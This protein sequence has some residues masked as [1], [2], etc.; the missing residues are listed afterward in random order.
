MHAD[1]C[2]IG[3]G[4]GG[5][6]A[7]AE[8]AEGGL[9]VVVLEEGPVRG[10][11]DATGRPR[12]TLPRLYRAGGQVATIGRPPLMLPLGRGTGGTTFVNSGTCFRTP[13]AVLDRWRAEHGIDGLTDAL[14]ERV[15]AALGVSE[16]TPE[17]AGRNAATIRRGAERLGWHGGYLRR[18][19]RGCR[20]S[21]VC[22]FGCPTGAKQHVG[23]VYLPRAL[24][25]GAE[26]VTGARAE[27][28]LVEHGRAGGASVRHAGG[29]RARHASATRAVGVLAST[30]AGPLTV[31]ADAVIVAA[32]AVHTPLLL[33][34]SGLGRSPA[35]GRQLTV[36]PATAVWGVFDE[37]VDMSRGVPQSY[38]VDE[39]AHEGFVFEGIAGPPDYLALA[40]PFSGDRLR[41]LMLG[42]RHVAQCGLMVTDRSRG[43]VASV[44]GRPVV[45][46]DLGEHDTRTFHSGL[47]R[48]TE[49]M[50]AAGARRVVLP[51]ARMPEL[52]DGD[53]RPLRQLDLRAR[54]LKLMGFHPLGTARAHP[55]PARGVVD[56]NLR[57]HG[58]R[59]VHVADGAAVPGPL[60]VNPQI[61]IMALAT[62]LAHHLMQ[63][64]VPACRS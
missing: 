60:G 39:F 24:E 20:G 34:R 49:L 29:V 30:A 46:Y 19:A 17:L 5:A 41:E 37:P 32:G 51:V 62:R 42:H 35:L 43:R 25:A 55:D 53:S 13:P 6:V 63:T 44:R 58:T 57:V 61:T 21:G 7:A 14:F 9:R 33:A 2:V 16:V 56:G 11:A 54:D 15:E 64:E 1:V 4:A 23:E 8:L 10:R 36:H 47:L 45:R 59:G 40:S 18:N 38:Y 48:L 22:A 12:D 50:R 31:R 3:S 52:R 27:R 26:I 28:I